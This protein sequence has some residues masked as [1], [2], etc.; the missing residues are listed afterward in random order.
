[1]KPR[2]SSPSKYSR[3]EQGRAYRLRPPAAGGHGKLLSHLQKARLNILAKQAFERLDAMGLIDSGV[4]LTAWRRGEQ[5]KATGI[6]SLTECRN[7]HFR[8]LMAHFLAA[9][10]MEDRAFKTS[11]R[12]GRVK[13]HGPAEDTHEAREMWR[14]KIMMEL[15]AH[16][17]RC[18]PAS[19]DFDPAIACAVKEKGV[20][21]AAY[22]VQIAKFQNKGKDLATLPAD[23][24]RQ[25]YYTCRNRIA[26]REGR[27][28]TADRNKSQKAKAKNPPIETEDPTDRR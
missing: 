21:T 23:K 28:K 25:I 10:G 18:D 8:P 3:A 6:A 27:G 20:I 26:A 22:I 13:D 12:T 5:E 16:G 9:A 17:R 11:M 7:S 15:L 2:A 24:L 1:M 4:T 14:T 19:P